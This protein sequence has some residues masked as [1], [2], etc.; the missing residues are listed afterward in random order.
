MDDVVLVVCGGGASRVIENAEGRIDIP[1]FFINSSSRS[2]IQMVPDD[3]EGCFGDQYLAGTIAFE[4][5]DRIREIFT[6]KRVAMIFAVLGGGT[7]TGMM[8]VIMEC[9]RECGC[10]VV[11][12]SGI[13]MMFEYTRREKAMEALPNIISMS[14]RSFILD[15]ETLNVL[16]PSIKLR[17]VLEVYSRTVAFALQNMYV[18]MEGPFFSLFSQRIYTFAYA[19]DM[20]PVTAVSKAMEIPMVDTDPSAGKLIL[21]VSSSFGTAE[22]ESMTDAIVSMSGILPEIVK[23]EDRED[24]KVLLFLS[25][26]GMG[27]C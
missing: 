13:P 21:Y 11:S 23:R 25:V 16:Y 4:N 6:G 3:V 9:A 12:I 22:K 26:K 7:G 18:T 10:K 24:T 8:P 15:V 20:D 1:T 14:D 5:I 27:H 19:S 17:N 2:S